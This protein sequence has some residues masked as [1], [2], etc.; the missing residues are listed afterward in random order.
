MK[1][2]S[3]FVSNSS[4]SSFICDVCGRSEGGFDVSL[5]DFEMCECVNGHVFCYDEVV[6]KEKSYTYYK[7]EYKNF[8]ELITDKF[9][10]DI[11]SI[12]CPICQMQEISDDDLFDYVYK[13]YKN[14]NEL[15]K[16]IK[17]KFENYNQFVEF[18]SQK[19]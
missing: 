11:P 1:I 16:E 12:Y 6:N 19:K 7:T 14:R 3:G 10:C 4:S 17:E 9:D 8:D 5:S 13:S 18:I 15:V 2:R